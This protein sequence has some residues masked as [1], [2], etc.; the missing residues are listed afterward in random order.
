MPA[1]DADKPASTRPPLEVHQ[2]VDPLLRWK[3]RL[4]Y[5]ALVVTLAWLGLSYA[6][7]GQANFH[8][9]RGPVAAVHQT[10]ETNCQA[11]HVDFTP[12]SSGSWV[13]PFLGDPAQ[14]T[15][16]CESCHA[17]PV[18]HAGQQPD[19]TCASCHRE[20]RGRDVSLV[21]LPDSDCTQCHRDLNNHR[22]QI[23]APF[24]RGFSAD[25]SGFSADGH[26]TFRS[27]KADP[28]KLKF[29]HQRHLAAGMALGK[30]GGALQT[31][32]KIPELYRKRY[33]DQQTSKED[34]APVQL[35]CA[36]CHQLDAGDFGLPA[37]FPLALLNQR[38][39]GAY[40]LPI[41]YENQC[42]ACHPLTLDQITVPHRWQPKELHAFLEN[43]FTAQ[44]ARGQA[45]F[46]DKKVVRPLPG[47]LPDLLTPTVREAIDK[48]VEFAEKDLYVSKRLC[49]ECHYFEGKSVAEAIKPG[50]APDLR[51]APPTVP[52]IWLRHAKFNHK[53]HRAVQCADCHAAA[54]TS[55][56]HTDVLIPDREVCVKCHAPVTSQGTPGARFNCTECHLYHNGD[57]GAQGLGAARRKPANARGIADFLK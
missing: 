31:L 13:A 56:V 26:P 6:L 47:K 34:D 25:I 16:R 50:A 36:S 8:A 52:T 40:M 38:P 18:H 20:H 30:D 23:A 14:S 15:Q 48:K 51:V 43:R 46:L 11:C 53:S 45:G 1:H 33:R 54:P 21:N 2:R 22:G 32:G 28:G 49:A 35:Q 42:Q 39:A 12:I 24:H 10:W 57:H 9:T 29:N 44:V 37:D 7:I 27:I 5:L 41:T 3:D 4:G 17:G 19:L 55:E